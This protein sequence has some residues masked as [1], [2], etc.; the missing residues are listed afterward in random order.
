MIKESLLV[1]VS[2]GETMREPRSSWKKH[3]S[4]GIWTDPLVLVRVN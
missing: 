2:V 1:I 4:R 3:T